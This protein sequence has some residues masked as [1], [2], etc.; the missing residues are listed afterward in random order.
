[1]IHFQL[2]KRQGVFQ[3]LSSSSS[4]SSS[5]PLLLILLLFL[6]LL[7]PPHFLSSE[8]KI[9][10]GS[11]SEFGVDVGVADGGRQSGLN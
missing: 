3:T 7:L 11:E 1:M 10:L 9:E 2:I 5:F 8:L 6:P 4:S